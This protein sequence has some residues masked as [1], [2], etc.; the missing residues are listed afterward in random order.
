MGGEELS[1]PGNS[2]ASVVTDPT[3]PCA[4]L[5]SV[6]DFEK[7][8][9]RGGPDVFSRTWFCGWCGTELKGWNATKA[10][11]H[12]SKAPGNNDVKP[13][14]GPIPKATLSLFEAFR[15]QKQGAATIKRQHKEAFADSVSE[16]Q[17]SL[18]VMLQNGRSRSSNASGCVGD[19]I[20]MTREVG[21]RGVEAS[22]AT[23]L[24]SAIADFVYSK[25]LSFNTTEGEQF[26]Q[27]LKLSRLVPSSYRPP[28]RKALANEL[29]DHSYDM[30]LN[31]YMN[32]L[33]VDS[34]VYGLSLF[35]DGATVHDMP[36]MNI[37]VSG[38]GEPCAVLEIVECKLL[39]ACFSLPFFILT[40]VIFVILFLCNRYGTTC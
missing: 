36:L 18:S 40:I 21:R 10:L 16:N 30:R 33:E 29:L 25:G 31:R 32:D 24:T 11:N 4:P 37:L 35:G 12:V 20:D 2:S 27:I 19:I 38:V 1:E 23:K 28:S 7:I 34:E 39:C 3:N 15:R 5:K 14:K 9:K 13:C 6:W 17:L 22:N 26:A 8:E